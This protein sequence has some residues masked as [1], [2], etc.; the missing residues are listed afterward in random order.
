[1]TTGF[2]AVVAHCTGSSGHCKTVCRK[3]FTW[4][5][6]QDDPC[7]LCLCGQLPR[8]VEETSV[9]VLLTICDA[10]PLVQVRNVD[11]DDCHASMMCLMS[12]CC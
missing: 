4:Y 10:V 5:W 1:M 11:V 9:P 2:Q 6:G 12:C 3:G 8:E 7:T